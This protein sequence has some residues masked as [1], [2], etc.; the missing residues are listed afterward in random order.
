MTMGRG[1]VG[2]KP[3][4]LVHWM[5]DVLNAH[6]DDE[7][8]DLFRVIDDWRAAYTGQPQGALFA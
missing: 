3:A 5:L 7:I 4:E 6:P 8:A 2:A 1:F